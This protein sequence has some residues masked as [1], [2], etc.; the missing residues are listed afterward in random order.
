[1]MTPENMAQIQR[2]LCHLPPVCSSAFVSS[3]VMGPIPTLELLLGKNYHR[4]DLLDFE[5][6]QLGRTPGNTRVVS[7][8]L[9]SNHSTYSGP[10]MKLE[11]NT[12]Y[13]LRSDAPCRSTILGVQLQLVDCSY[14]LTGRLER[15]HWTFSR[16]LTLP[17]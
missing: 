16:V 10:K 4:P 1:M 12:C 5:Y 9:T 6:S 3:C 17:C 13:F 11:A 8:K 15:G 14:S 7:R 2:W